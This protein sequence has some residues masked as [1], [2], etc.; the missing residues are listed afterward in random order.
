MKYEL[1]ILDS[2]D[3]KTIGRQTPFGGPLKANDPFAKF[4]VVLDDV[5][6]GVHAFR[7]HM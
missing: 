4:L 5:T 1:T 2:L 3:E 7:E 6:S